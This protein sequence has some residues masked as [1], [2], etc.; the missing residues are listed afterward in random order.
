MVVQRLSSE[1]NH[2]IYHVPTWP[3]VFRICFVCPIPE[4]NYQGATQTPLCDN[5]HPLC[6]SAVLISSRTLRS[7]TPVFL[8]TYWCITVF[9][10]WALALTH[11]FGD[12]YRQE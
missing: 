12:K 4:N 1:F 7:L 5:L 3:V 9:L 11:H 8:I 10:E 6:C 2:Y